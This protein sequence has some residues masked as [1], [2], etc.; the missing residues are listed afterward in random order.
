MTY[1]PTLSYAMNAGL[2]AVRNALPD[3]AD[4]DNHRRT[5]A[6]SD[7]KPA[8]KVS[9]YPITAAIWR[10]ET[11]KGAFYSVTFEITYKDRDGNFKSGSSYS[12]ED[13]LLLAKVANAAHTEMY[14]LRSADR[15]AQRA[16]DQA[17]PEDFG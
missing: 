1:D 7:K 14:K 15:A 11:D 13:A 5:A 8:S 10:N 2:A 16:T 12:V 4:N 6:M 9:M 3:P 17:P